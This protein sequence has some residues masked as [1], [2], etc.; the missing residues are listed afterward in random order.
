MPSDS[1]ESFKNMFIRGASFCKSA[2]CLS[3]EWILRGQYSRERKKDRYQS[4]GKF[5]KRPWRPYNKGKRL[6]QTICSTMQLKYCP[7]N[8]FNGLATGHKTCVLCPL[9]IDGLDKK[10][11]NGRPY[12]LTT[13][14]KTLLNIVTCAGVNLK[15]TY[16]SPQL[17]VKN[18]QKT[19]LQ[20]SV[21]HNETTTLHSNRS[22]S[23]THLTLPT[24]RI[25]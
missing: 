21:I 13:V 20:S 18:T 15:I 17:L 5:I 4:Q 14:R 11:I 10:K 19:L 3:S 23:Y 12:L 8:I 24:K 22:V 9:T 25:V 7:E 1:E 6:V 16:M 2:N